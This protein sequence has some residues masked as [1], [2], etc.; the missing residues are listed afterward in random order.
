MSDT[1]IS[2]LISGGIALLVCIITNQATVK[3]AMTI[4]EV[5]LDALSKTV[6]KHNSV[7]ERTFRLEE[8]TNDQEKRLDALQREFHELSR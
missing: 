4:V 5:K 3:R 2:S 1:I 6:E 7:V 8:R